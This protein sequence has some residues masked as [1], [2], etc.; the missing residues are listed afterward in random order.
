[1]DDVHLIAA[2]S[3]QSQVECVCNILRPHVGAE[4][5]RDD[6]SAVIVQNCAEIE[7]TPT[8]NLN[9]PGFTGEHF[10]QNL[11][12]FFKGVQVFVESF[13]RF[14]WREISDST[15]DAFCVVPIDPFQRFPFQLANG[16]P[17]AE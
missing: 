14:S 17:G 4:L 10:V 9:R 13:L 1:M 16:F 7:P 15:V 8:D 12:C 5:P 11:R 2:R 3:L 6:I